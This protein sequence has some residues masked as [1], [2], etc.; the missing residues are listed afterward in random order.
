MQ[1]A[2]FGV[3]IDSNDYQVSVIK[4]VVDLVHFQNDVIGDSSFSE[5]NVQLTRHATSDW[6]HSKFNFF[7]FFSELQSDFGHNSS[8]LSNC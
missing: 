2:N 6:M 3:Q 5:Q 1:W 8:C 7:S 4:V